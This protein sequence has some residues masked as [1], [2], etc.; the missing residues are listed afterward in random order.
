MNNNCIYNNKIMVV[1]SSVFELILKIKYIPEKGGTVIADSF[2]TGFGG[3]G[4]NQAITISELGGDVSFLT[5]IG[6]DQYGNELAQNYKN[7]NFNLDL[8]K[9]IKDQPSGLAVIFLEESGQ[10]IIGVYPGANN[11]LGGTI[12]EDNLNEI[13]SADFIMTQ[14]EIPLSSVELLSEKK[15]DNNV[16]ILNPSP[17]VMSANYSRLL[18]NVDILIPNEI[19][20]SC[21][22]GIRIYSIKDI[23]NAS[24]KL[25][26]TGVKNVVVTLGNN[27]VF[28]KNSS[29]EKHIKPQKVKVVDT[30]GAGDIFAGS[31]TFFYSLSRDIIKAAE[32][33]NN[34]A[35]LS[36][37][38][39]GTQKSIPLKDEIIEINKRF[40]I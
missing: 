39:H 4:A 35:A 28:I 38:R 20:L 8:I 5:C 7:R 6:D 32:Y 34:I 30:T 40:G 29:I 11:F 18:K 33:G 16:F 23:S 10:N 1:G 36:V 15:K 31:F 14:L 2:N 26:K 17:V 12:I 21:L 13:F 37:T 3:K 22:T 25:L 9:V 19:E 24:K 27:G